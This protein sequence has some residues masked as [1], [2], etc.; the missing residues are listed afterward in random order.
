MRRIKNKSILSFLTSFILINISLQ[1]DTCTG[2]TTTSGED[3]YK[4]GST[5]TYCCYLYNPNDGSTSGISSKICYSQ[6]IANYTTSVSKITYQGNSY[7][8]NCPDTE[9]SIK[10]GVNSPTS[11][12]NCH[13]SS[14]SNNSCCYYS[15]GATTGCFLY[16]SK[17]QGQTF[18]EGVYLYCKGFYVN[19]SFFNVLILILVAF[20]IFN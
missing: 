19:S 4:Y 13:Q 1:A 18:Q 11:P 12:D 2:L 7:S 8:I 14:T 16:G 10:C 6:L 17:F 9:T 3:C 5:Y 15:Y 20:L